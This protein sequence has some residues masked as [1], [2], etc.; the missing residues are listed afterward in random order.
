MGTTVA[1][2]YRGI[3]YRES[4]TRRHGSRP[5]RYF[6][7][8]YKING[9]SKEEGAGWASEGMTAQKASQIRAK[10]AENIRLGVKPQSLAEMRGMLQAAREQEVAEA[11]AAS[12]AATSFNQFWEEHY[13]P[14]SR[15]H[16][17]PQ[18]LKTELGYYNKWIRSVI[19]SLPLVELSAVHISEVTAV[20]LDAN[21]SAATIRHLIA[22][23]S[24]VWGL[25]KQ[26]GIVDGECPCRR[27]KKP[28][29]DNRRM[30]FL[31]E[32]EASRLLEELRARSQDTHDSA[33]LALLCGMR[34]GEIHDLKWSDLSLENGTIYIRDPKNKHSR[35]AFMTAEVKAMLEGRILLQARSEY[36]FSTQAGTKRR[37]VSDT[38]ERSVEN[39]GLNAGISDPRLRVVFHTLRH[40]FA[41]WLVQKGTPLYTVAE[42]MGHTTLEMT[43]RYAHLSPD[44]VRKAAMSLQGILESKSDIAIT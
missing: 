21:K 33:L 38:F 4:D 30:R 11:E 36:V 6:F 17:T 2:T 8:R 32:V 23:I 40:T 41:S 34:A 5:D 29:K 7:I 26:H 39:L 43:K 1:T 31:S 20:A 27:V 13:L 42:L 25:A 28:R 18:T 37:W 22:I 16:K 3:R 15:L 44:T 24:Q 9:K 35:H 19:G 14:S 12:R 10:L